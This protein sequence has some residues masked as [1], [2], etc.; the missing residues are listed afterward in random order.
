MKRLILPLLLIV[1]V[2]PLGGCIVEGPGP[3][4]GCHWWH[5]C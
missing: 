4:H 1:F 2:L 3:Y 5:R